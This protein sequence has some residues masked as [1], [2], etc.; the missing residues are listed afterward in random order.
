MSVLPLANAAQDEQVCQD[1]DDVGRGELPPNADCQA[2]AGELVQD[3]EHAEGPAVMG[4]VMHEVIGPDMVRPLGA[5]PD[6]GSVV[7]PEPAPLRLLAGHLQ[8]LAPP[9]ALDSL[10]VQAAE[11]VAAHPAILLAP[12]VVGD[13]ADPQLPDRVRHRHALAMQN[14]RLPQQADDLLRLVA[15]PCHL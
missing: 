14:L 12:S 3:V 1:I 6:A 5:Q 11:L 4:P 9:Q 2:L 15:L 10:V 7:E 13:L 8:P